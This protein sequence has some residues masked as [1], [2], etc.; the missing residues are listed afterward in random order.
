[1]I[2]NLSATLNTGTEF[3]YEFTLSGNYASDRI[4]A[5]GSPRNQVNPDIEFNGEIVEKGFVT[6]D[7]ILNKQFNENWSIGILARNLLN[8]TVR[9]T[10]F[11][12]NQVTGE[13]STPNILTYTTG[14]D[15]RITLR[16][17]F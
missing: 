2:T 13:E 3:P 8:P 15:S 1:M 4:F 7:F 10:Q 9:R 6:L 12:R 14:I 5:I 17:R 16:Y 11:L